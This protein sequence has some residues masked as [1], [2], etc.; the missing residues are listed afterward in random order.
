MGLKLTGQQEASTSQLKCSHGWDL[1][2]P[3]PPLSIRPPSHDILN[4]CPKYVSQKCTCAQMLGSTGVCFHCLSRKVRWCSVPFSTGLGQPVLKSTAPFRLSSPLDA[5]VTLL[6]L[7]HLLI[8]E[9]GWPF[10]LPCGNLNLKCPCYSSQQ[11]LHTRFYYSS[12]ALQL[13]LTYFY[14]K[15]PLA[16]FLSSLSV[17]SGMYLEGFVCLFLT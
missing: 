1:P 9:W 8:C 10:L 17:G 5:L 12:W 4:M 11:A 7:Q 2:A 3:S 16:L 13:F 6:T 15:I 14:F